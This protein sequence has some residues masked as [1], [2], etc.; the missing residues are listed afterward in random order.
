MSNN[1]PTSNTPKQ[2]SGYVALNAKVAELEKEF[3]AFIERDAK[4]YEALLAR[5]DLIEQKLSG[6][7]SEGPKENQVLKAVLD[8]SV[9]VLQ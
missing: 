6:T 1:N 2:A 3:K 8:K 5:I 9:T 7:I 4:R